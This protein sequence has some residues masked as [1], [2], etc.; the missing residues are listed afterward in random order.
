MDWSDECHAYRECGL[1][2]AGPARSACGGHAPTSLFSAHSRSAA[3]P[4]DPS[5]RPSAYERRTCSGEAWIEYLSSLE[6]LTQNET[7]IFQLNYVPRQKGYQEHCQ[8]SCVDLI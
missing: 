1:R 5:L 8:D 7:E 4:S 2:S 6:S 3:V